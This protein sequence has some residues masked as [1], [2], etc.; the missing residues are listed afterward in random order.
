MWLSIVGFLVSAFFIYLGG[1][2]LSLYGDIISKE[3]G[4]GRIWIGLILMASVTSLP[5][6]VI[7]ISSVTIVGSA[8]MAV[9]NVLGSC[10][11]NL[12]IL[13]LM[14][15]I[16]PGQ[17]L[18]TRLANSHVLAATLCTILLAL[19]GIGL[20]LPNEIVILDWIGVTSIAFIFVYLISMRMLNIHGLKE[21]ARLK[22]AQ[23]KLS[24]EGGEDTPEK[25]DL[26][27][28]EIGLNRAI[29]YF[30]LN[31]LVVI[32]AALA[33]PSFSVTIAEE[34]GL[35]ESFV[36][37][38]FMAA[39]SSLPEIVVSVSAAR[40]GAADLAA[41][42][43]FGSNIFNIMLLSVSDLFYTQGNLLKDASEANIVTVFAITIMNAIAIAGL[44]TRV[45]KKELHYLTWDT[46][47]IFLIYLGALVY[48]FYSG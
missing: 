6:L 35:G 34:S 31:A 43:L 32:A 4:L 10:I 7:G 15:A 47:F 30:A 26:K 27:H 19:V 38:L 3:T 48:L 45:E 5:E 24:F 16:L 42:N 37:T 1:R 36:A 22:A 2:R 13:S 8:D 23:M 39:S 44:T 21:Q 20:F 9:G 11:F 33:L 25:E 18:F 28:M 46:L 12:S 17:P 41:G 40:M 29:L 14:D